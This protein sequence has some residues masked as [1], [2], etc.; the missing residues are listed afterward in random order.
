MDEAHKGLTA[1]ELFNDIINTTAFSA[2]Q[3]AEHL[4][5]PVEEILELI[6]HWV[7]QAVT[8]NQ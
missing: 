7:D 5:Q 4:D 6:H 3:L 8:L 1:E 2:L